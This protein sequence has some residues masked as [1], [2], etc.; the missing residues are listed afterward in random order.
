[1]LQDASSTE[2]HVIHQYS[3]ISNNVREETI[4]LESQQP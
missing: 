1:M 3:L 2:A 4:A